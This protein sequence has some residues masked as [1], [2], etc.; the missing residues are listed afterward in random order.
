MNFS[1]EKLRTP[2]GIFIIYMLVSA[3]L[4]MIFRF[5]FPGSEIPVLVFS[6]TWRLTRGI[7]TFFNLFPALAFS[8]LV[9]P[10][11]LA[12]IEEDYQ[13]FS[14]IF[15]K[16]LVVSVI[17]AICSAALYGGIF[18]FAL[19]LVKNN[20]EN[21]RFKGEL[22]HLAKE[23]A[24]LRGRAGDWLEASQFIAICD[25]VWPDSPELASLRTEVNINLDRVRI[26]EI[27]E[28]SLAR[29]ALA[30]DYRGSDITSL[31][32]GWQPLDAT[33]AIALSETA[34]RE[35]RFFDAHWLAVVAGRLAIDG[36]PEA[37][38]AAR[39][40]SDAWNQISSQ[41]PD[42]R[43]T[44]MFNIYN[45]KL[46]GYQAMNSG[47]WVR[48]YYI[49]RE[50][51]ILTPDDPDAINFLAAS[52]RGAKEVAFFLDEIE[53]AF[54]EILTGAVFSLPGHRNIDRVV[55]R[56]FSLSISA[57]VAYGIG[58]EYMDFDELARP[59]KSVRAPYT[60]LLPITLNERP[61]VL[62]LTH[63]LDRYDN[64]HSWESE[65]LLG[66]ETPGGIILDISFEDFILLFHV[67]QGLSNLHINEL[68][69][70]SKKLGSMG[71]I[72]QIFEAEIL[73]RF[74]SILFFLP[75]AI[76]VIVFGWRFRAKTKPRYL[77]ML[78][79]FVM[80]V[81]FYGIVFLY[82]KILNSLGIW[83]VLSLGFTSALAAL[84][85]ALVLLL[86]VS[87]IALASQQRG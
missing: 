43:E 5:I 78:L 12:T 23:N 65:W 61:R 26:A 36:S 7:V 71:Y 52:E 46:S 33:Q 31:Y 76:F 73:N 39:R 35:R 44:R 27:E 85:V 8:A 54:G 84:V 2:Y 28:R 82:R 41:A 59:V 13:S 74:G 58:F 40:A 62:V 32:N 64:N 51:L 15:Y 4:I 50:L 79:L 21:M 81:V 86:F 69:L 47:D 87:M 53:M 75:M 45:L 63:A 49:F 83:L 18:F 16:R 3:L 1:V 9:I 60:K 25:R 19:P 80:P 24:H 56:F 68:F 17:V 77:F 6:R 11:G 55:A 72:P 38:N 42:F 22:Y 48:A 37:A 34:F 57:D 10:F 29:S 20:E 70:A 67:R 14:E 30:R 66:T